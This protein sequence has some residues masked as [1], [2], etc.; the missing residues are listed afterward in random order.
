MVRC[1]DCGKPIPDGQIIRREVCIGRS[2]HYGSSSRHYSKVNLCPAC[3]AQRDYD[4]SREV[5]KWIGEMIEWIIDWIIDWFMESKTGRIILYCFFAMILFL[6]IVS[7]IIHVHETA[8]PKNNKIDQT[9]QIDNKSTTPRF[10]RGDRFRLSGTI[11]K[12]I[13]VDSHIRP[14][15]IAVLDITIMHNGIPGILP[16]RTETFRVYSAPEGTLSIEVHDLDMDKATGK[17][18]DFVIEWRENGQWLLVELVGKENKIDQTPQIDNKP[19]TPVF[20]KGNRLRLSG[21]I[22]KVE[23]IYVRSPGTVALDITIMYNRVPGVLAE[24][25]RAYSDP[26][27]PLN[28]KIRDLDITKAIGREVDFVIEWHENGQ[29]LLVELVGKK[30][31]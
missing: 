16:S 14:S 2:E 1:Y 18:V 5:I 4:P 8:K 21:T 7:G 11:T 31:K 19:T 15:G 6:C 9:Q 3:A 17:E 27:S 24:T 20:K 23:T 30:S 10:K 13:K 12:I 25:F 26:E 22:T 28:I 29:W